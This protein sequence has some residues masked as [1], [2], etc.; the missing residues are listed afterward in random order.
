MHVLP[1]VCTQSTLRVAHDAIDSD[2]TD[3]ALLQARRPRLNTWNSLCPMLP[4]SITYTHRE[5]SSLCD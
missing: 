4:Q 3:Y 5:T 1:H 2:F